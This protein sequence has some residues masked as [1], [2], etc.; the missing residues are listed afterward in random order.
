MSEMLF[1]EPGTKIKKMAT[2]IFWLELIACVI[3]AF[4]L[5]W[6]RSYRHDKFLPGVFF[7]FLIGGPLAA[8]CSALML[9]GFGELVEKVGEIGRS[10]KT[11]ITV[12]TKFEST[13]P[14]KPSTTALGKTTPDGKVKC[15]ACGHEQP[16]SNVTCK[17][18]GES[19]Y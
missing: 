6:D 3:L 10:N 11:P 1:E 7:G 17:M 4:V 18:C 5:G 13:A 9:H 2:F 15:W 14:K 8:Y 16:R 19:L 12:P